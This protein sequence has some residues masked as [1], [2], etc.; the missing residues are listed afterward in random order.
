MLQDCNCVWDTI[1]RSTETGMSALGLWSRHHHHHGCPSSHCCLLWCPHRARVRALVVSPSPPPPSSVNSPL[2]PT[3]ASHSARLDSEACL[4]SKLCASF[5][6]CS[7]FNGK[8]VGVP[9]TIP[10]PPQTL[11]DSESC[12]SAH[13]VRV[14]KSKVRFVIVRGFVPTHVSK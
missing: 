8:D 9:I 7:D 2:H 11:N 4:D 3:I 13:V 5:L 6:A 14:I 12:D 10:P 1:V